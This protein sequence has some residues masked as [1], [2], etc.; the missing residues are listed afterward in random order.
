[1]KFTNLENTIKELNAPTVYE[2]GEELES[3]FDFTYQVFKN[4]IHIYDRNESYHIDYLEELNALNR[5]CAREFGFEYQPIN[6]DKIFTKLT[7]AIQKD[8]SKEHYIEW[9][10]N[11][12]M[13]VYF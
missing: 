7:E 10:D 3:P 1:M 11:V 6:E 8:I 5:D 12:V 4:Y 9:E 13:S 2:D